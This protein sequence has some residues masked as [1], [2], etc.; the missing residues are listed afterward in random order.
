M[1]GSS[2]HAHLRRR[3]AA[4]TLVEVV[5]A[6]GIVAFGLT[7]LVGLLPTGLKS[8]RDSIEESQAVNVMYSV[9]ADR[10]STPLDQVSAI[11]QLPA[12]EN[13]TSQIQASLLLTEDGEVT[14]QLDDAR[15]RIEYTVR[16]SPGSHQP[17][18]MAVRISW[19]ATQVDRPSAIETIATFLVP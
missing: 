12:L 17:V 8:N 6:L 16:P 10:Q 13:V 9:I 11:Y 3:K 19:P 4:F 15:Y 5:V 7:V 2:S 18:V 1:F 14:P